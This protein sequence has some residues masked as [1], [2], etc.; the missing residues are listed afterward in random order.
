MLG[1]ILIEL[2]P[3]SRTVIDDSCNIRCMVLV[4]LVVWD[5][6][7]LHLLLLL[8]LLWRSLLTLRALHLALSC[9]NLL[10]VYLNILEV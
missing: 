10:G 2:N 4:L 9:C 3:G 8:H 1:R 5:V 7:R 6:L